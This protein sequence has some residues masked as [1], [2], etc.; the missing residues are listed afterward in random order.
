MKKIIFL[1]LLT[2]VVFTKGYTQNPTFTWAKANYGYVN[3]NVEAVAIDSEG[4][5]I[6]VGVFRSS[7]DLTTGL[8]AFN[9]QGNV[10][11]QSPI[12]PTNSVLYGDSYLVKYNSSGELLWYN[13]T[14]GSL[15]ESIESVTTDS[16]NNI[17]VCGTYKSS[18][19]TIFSSSAP[20]PIFGIPGIGRAFVM[21]ISPTGSVL[22]FQ[23]VSFNYSINNAADFQFINLETDLSGNV[24]AS[25]MFKTDSISTGSLSLNHVFG[26]PNQY[27]NEAC[28]FKFDNNGTPIWLKGIQGSDQEVITK[29]GVD[30]TGSVYFSGVTYSPNLIISSS[31][32]PTG[33]NTSGSSSFTTKLDANGNVVWLDFSDYAD[34]SLF[35]FNETA[36][37]SQGNVYCVGTTS[38]LGLGPF[39]P[40]TITFGPSSVTIPYIPDVRRDN[41]LVVCKYSPT[42]EKLWM[43]TSP[44]NLH[45]KGTGIEIDIND[46]IYI[47]GQYIVPTNFGGF[48]LPNSDFVS[49]SSS[50]SNPNYKTFVA[51][52]DT[53]GTVNW[54]RQTGQH[55][56]LETKDFEVDNNG[57]IVIGGKF[58]QGNSINFDGS[59][60]SGYINSSGFRDSFIAKFN[61]LATSTTAV[62]TARS[63]PFGLALDATNRLYIAESG[64]IN[65][66][67]ISRATLTDT[68]PIATPLFTTSLNR[69]TRVKWSTDNYLYATETGSNEISRANLGV[70][71]PIMQSYFNE[72]L[73]MPMGLDVV[74]NTLFVGDFGSTSI[75]NIN[76]S[77]TPFQVNAHVADYASDIVND[78]TSMYF[79]NNSSS[80][81]YKANIL[82][83]DAPI[84]VIAD[85]MTKPSSV[86]LH[87]NMLY[88]SDSTNG[89]IYRINPYG[90]ST[91]PELLIS[92]LNAPNGMVIF[93]NNLYIAETT[94]NR[95]VTFNLSS[96]ST[97]D[98][99]DSVSLF[100]VFPNPTA[101]VLNFKIKNEINNVEVFDVSGNLILKENALD[102]NSLSV[103][104]LSS[105]LYFVKVTSL[106]KSQ[107]KKFIK[108]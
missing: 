41:V 29:I 37:D 27:R 68:Q 1:L 15:T 20:N 95:V 12:D 52:L 103:S 34:I 107:T 9:L 104:N 59:I 60:L 43:K 21:K 77:I 38:G 90:S 55:F 35:G 101:D 11:Q 65:G 19:T 76:T 10:L 91:T 64:A 84:V 46:N 96:L 47:L 78:G 69:P 30:N 4:N 54:A 14:Q 51:S 2:T 26:S 94:A 87:N 98:I 31:S 62:F 72:G 18:N 85:G 25:A 56:S 23:S 73:N 89:S 5:V 44:Y 28:I 93:N 79:V 57:S 80:N 83:A 42:G 97:V 24:Y 81:V 99:E 61:T 63:N 6:E 67:K 100:E 49:N 33:N 86:L 88:I 39:D 108:L 102:S 45:I 50:L 3:D 22:W 105:G 48:T 7:T 66:N 82:D 92:G 36:A 16:N 17:Y 32:Y 71:S 40:H 70:T 74:G 106:D 53:D 58:I 13:R 75:K 8:G